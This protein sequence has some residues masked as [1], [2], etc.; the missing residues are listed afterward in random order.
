M[1]FIK[2]CQQ[3]NLFI[4]TTMLDSWLKNCLSKGKITTGLGPII[5][6]GYDRYHEG[7]AILSKT[8]IEAREFLV[9]DV[10]DQRTIILAA[11][12]WLKQ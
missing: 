3:L 6:S 7:V 12:P 2:L 4:K 5:I 8:P 1:T 11:L 9:S 10:D